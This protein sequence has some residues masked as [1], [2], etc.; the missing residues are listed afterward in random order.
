MDWVPQLFEQLGF[1]GGVLVLIGVAVGFWFWR[2]TRDIKLTFERKVDEIKTDTQGI[3]DAIVTNHGSANMGKAV[4][5]QFEM[6][7][8]LDNKLNIHIAESEVD[9]AE[10]RAER[11]RLDR[12]IE[13][14]RPVIEWGKI[15]MLELETRI[16]RGLNGHA[17]E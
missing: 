15:H 13:E 16:E 17:H 8:A 7:T 1:G 11:R 14:S 5:R 9:R 10:S 3:A 6:L 2:A 4:D 12:H